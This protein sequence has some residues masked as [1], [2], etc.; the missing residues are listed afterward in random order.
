QQVM[1]TLRY[2]APEQLDG[3]R[4][5]DHRADIYS[6]G[7][8]FYEMLT[9]QVPVGHF[10]P[11]S[12]KVHIDVR[13]DEVVLRSL[14]REPARRYQHAS[15]IRTDVETCSPTHVQQAVTSS[16]EVTLD[17]KLAADVAEVTRAA[18]LTEIAPD[19]HQFAF[20]GMFSSGWI[21][22]VLLWNWRWP[23]LMLA[24]VAMA[25]IAAYAIQ[26]KLKYLPRLSSEL[27]RESRIA[28]T[29]RLT[30]AL[31]MFA[32]GFLCLIWFQTSLADTVSNVTPIA[33]KQNQAE[34]K[35]QLEVARAAGFNV[36][37]GETHML[38]SGFTFLSAHTLLAG[39]W[40]VTLLAGAFL[41]VLHTRRFRNTWKHHWAPSLE[42]TFWIIG[43]LVVVQ[44]THLLI[45]GYSSASTQ[46][47][48]IISNH[49]FKDVQAAL[50]AWMTRS[51]YQQTAYADAQIDDQGA[52]VG[53]IN[54]RDIVPSSWFDRYR[55][56]W[57]HLVLRPSPAMLLTTVGN[58]QTGLSFV[59]IE[60][61]NHLKGSPE[62]DW[63]ESITSE[64]EAELQ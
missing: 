27:H 36:P 35:R 10:E 17:L 19:W 30:T 57:S 23:G 50:D 6:L 53:N 5:V 41:T 54:S 29:F 14:A 39:S 26:L 38:S 62:V 7:V 34:C 49:S 25:A 55:M 20:I 58:V 2:M 8:V 15:E 56:S 16:D 12:K 22:I 32:I 47:K 44:M 46:R 40:G 43:T 1:G 45:T 37:L 51:H 31:V 21:L 18:E 4:Q 59:H 28:Q 11:P 60:L 13:L 52:Q 24:I 63:W 3:S 9:G 48:T 42:I 61:P 33:F 64:L